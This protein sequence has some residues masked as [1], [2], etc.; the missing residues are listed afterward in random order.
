MARS[1][2]LRAASACMAGGCVRVPQGAFTRDGDE[3][4]GVE[5]A[6]FA[7]SAADGKQLWSQISNLALQNRECRRRGGALLGKGKG[8]GSWMGRAVRRV[9]EAWNWS[10]RGLSTASSN[11]SRVFS[12]SFSE[13]VLPPFRSQRR[14]VLLPSPQQR[15]SRWAGGGVHAIFPVKQ[16]R[17]S[18][19]SSPT[20]HHACTMHDARPVPR[21]ARVDTLPRTSPSTMPSTGD[22]YAHIHACCRRCTRHSLVEHAHAVEGPRMSTSTLSADPK[23]SCG[24]ARTPDLRPAASRRRGAFAGC[25]TP[26]RR[27]RSGRSCGRRRT[28]HDLDEGVRFL[29]RERA[30]QHDDA[31]L[32]KAS[33]REP[34]RSTR[35]TRKER[36]VSLKRGRDER[37]WS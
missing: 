32:L 25:T 29:V 15:C 37:D 30:A 24:S 1:C 35:K 18:S 21:R 4:G 9:R 16:A 14:P 7:I 2:G 33:M 3:G 28:R 5:G 26:S 31:R 17:V 36:S 34:E 11:M 22:R 6:R 10:H 20:I 8:S 23:H 27:S 19:S 12:C 13:C